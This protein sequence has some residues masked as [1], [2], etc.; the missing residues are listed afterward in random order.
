[1]LAIAD[2]AYAPGNCSPRIRRLAA[3]G[4]V[5][6]MHGPF[7]RGLWAA[8]VDLSRRRNLPSDPIPLRPHR[9]GAAGDILLRLL[10]AADRSLPRQLLSL[11]DPRRL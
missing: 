9:E 4:L 7:Q 8:V 5:T 10:S 2:A 3:T 1:M 11:L 6:V